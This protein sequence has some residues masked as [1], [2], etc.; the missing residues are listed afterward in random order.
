[1]ENLRS[2][3]RVSYWYQLGSRISFF[4]KCDKLLVWYC[5]SLR[6][7]YTLS[8]K[9]MWCTPSEISKSRLKNGRVGRLT[10]FPKTG[11]RSAISRLKSNSATGGSSV[12]DPNLGVV[13]VTFSKVKNVTSIWGPSSWV[14]DG[15]SWHFVSNWATKKTLLLSIILDG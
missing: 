6:R 1:M 12:R 15:R 3:A 4:Q 9:K 7:S 8:F 2:V 13:Y 14:T 11:R 5:K 10:A